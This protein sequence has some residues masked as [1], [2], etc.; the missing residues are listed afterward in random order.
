MFDAT[1]WADLTQIGDIRDGARP[2]VFRS[3]WMSR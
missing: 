3:E 1:A 2:A